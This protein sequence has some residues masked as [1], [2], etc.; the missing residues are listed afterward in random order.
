[1]IRSLTGTSL[2]EYP[3]RICSVIFLSGC[4]LHCPFCHNPELVR[5]DLL[6]EEFGLTQDEV[7][8]EL[9]AREG[10][11]EAVTITGG[12]PML[13]EG[14]LDLVRRIKD[15]TGLAVK[16]DTNGTFPQR[17]NEIIHFVDYVAMDL[18]SSP[19]GY[20]RATGE[21]ASFEDVR[22]SISIVKSL[23]EYE[24]RTTMVPGIV[25]GKDV[26]ELLGRTGKVKR[27][28][29]QTFHSE[30]TLSDEFREV[31]AYP[32]EYLQDICSEILSSGL[33]EHVS[34]RP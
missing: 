8:R 19:S 31:S 6:E 17:L 21:R 9:S 30:K 14:I 26:M 12:E 24:F 4:N 11:V 22:E 32:R 29:L 10:F 34:I 28:V 33:A 23:P 15:E 2:I 18:K 3:G 16:M 27:Y 5:P 25:D 1:L 13:Y 20:L 7:L